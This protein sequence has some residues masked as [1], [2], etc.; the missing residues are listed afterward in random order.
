MISESTRCNIIDGLRIADMN[1]FGHL[2]DIDFLQRIF[3]LRALP[4]N[5]ERYDNAE[6]DI[7]QHRVANYDWP[8]EWLFSDE[9]FDLLHI[10]DEQFLK[11]LCELLHPIVRPDMAEVENLR[12]ILNNLLRVDGWELVEFMRIAGHPVFVARQ[13]VPGASQ[14]VSS[15]R[16]ILTPGNADYIAQQITRMEAAMHSDPDVAIGTA[17]EMVESVCKAILDERNVSYSANDDF[18]HLVRA[19]IR[20]LQLVPN[21]VTQ[22]AQTAEILRVF[23]MSLGTVSQKLAE[24]RNIH[25][26][27][28]GQGSGYTGL[29]LRHARLA[30][31]AASALSVFLFETHKEN[32]QAQT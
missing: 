8:N 24:L 2:K 25:G 21:S 20:E 14:A 12:V 15:A 17:K 30:V 22:Q 3:D 27:G 1:W 6:D 10:S 18:P 32:I 5:D 29:E 23:G 31:H 19:T 28:H 26:I 11:F 7:Y 16:A 4:S 9:R 13:L